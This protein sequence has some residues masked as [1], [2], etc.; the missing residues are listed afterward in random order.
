MKWLLRR[1]LVRR[2]VLALLL[3]FGLAWIAVASYMYVDFRVS[4]QTN[5]G[6]HLVG[7]ALNA[8]LAKVE[9]ADLAGAV[10]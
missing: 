6:L 1:T 2:V 8:T 7:R 4:M 5:S 3:A 10:V 9:Q